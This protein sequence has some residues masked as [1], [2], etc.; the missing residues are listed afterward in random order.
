MMEGKDDVSVASSAVLLY[1]L[2]GLN[3][4]LKEPPVDRGVA[5]SC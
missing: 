1:W 4:V 3:D 5:D 2:E